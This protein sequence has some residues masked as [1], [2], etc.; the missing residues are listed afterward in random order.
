M[1]KNKNHSDEGYIQHKAICIRS[2]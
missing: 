2:G 1:I